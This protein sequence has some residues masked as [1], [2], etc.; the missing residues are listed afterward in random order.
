MAAQQP[1]T[2]SGELVD[3]DNVAHV[4]AKD[5]ALSTDGQFQKMPTIEK[6]DAFGAHT[7]TDPKEIAL[8]RKLDWYMLVCPHCDTSAMLC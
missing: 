1:E 5:T 4:E 7:K 6:V 8:V 3:K 2:H